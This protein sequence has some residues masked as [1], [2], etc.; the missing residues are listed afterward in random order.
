MDA[1]ELTKN[2][3]WDDVPETQEDIEG[4]KLADEIMECTETLVVSALREKGHFD[5]EEVIIPLPNESIPPLMLKCLDDNYSDYSRQSIMSL[6]QS[7]FCGKMKSYT[8]ALTK[9]INTEIIPT[10]ERHEY[11]YTIHDLGIYDNVDCPIMGDEKEK[12]FCKLQ[13]EIV[14]DREKRDELEKDKLTRLK[15]HVG[16]ACAVAL[17]EQIKMEKLKESDAKK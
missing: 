17:E 1:N 13:V 7:L 3:K 4:Y 11:I 2:F 16:N 15:E 8:E 6:I 9:K 5:G 12:D 10:T 14:M